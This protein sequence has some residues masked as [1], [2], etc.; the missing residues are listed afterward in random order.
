M[1]SIKYFPY[2]SN[3]SDADIEQ[4]GRQDQRNIHLNG[5]QDTDRWP[6]HYARAY[7]KGVQNERHT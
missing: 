3:Y 5:L 4:M 1:R 7:S 2:N 6:L